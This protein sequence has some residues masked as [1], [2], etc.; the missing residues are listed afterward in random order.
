[1]SKITPTL[2]FDGQAEEAARYYTSIFPDSQIT[3]VARSAADNPS[4]ARG[5]VITVDFTIGGQPFIGL[6]GGPDFPFTEA[7]SFTIDCKDQAEVDGYSEALISDG[8]AQGPCGWVKDRFG[9]SW[10]VVPRQ[11]TEMLASSDRDGAARAME[12]MLKMQKID[13]EKLR[14]AFEGVP[15]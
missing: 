5:E 9:L 15:A 10:Q 2:W 7:V 6:N 1:M 13:V 3:N 11:L 4:T 14:E 12:A 8:G